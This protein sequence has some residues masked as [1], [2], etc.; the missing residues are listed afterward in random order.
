MSPGANTAPSLQPP[1]QKVFEIR[2]LDCISEGWNFDKGGGV[3]RLALRTPAYGYKWNTH[4][5]GSRGQVVPG[6][7]FPNSLGDGL[8]RS[9]VQFGECNAPC[10]RQQEGEACGSRRRPCVG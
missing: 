1:I 9:A 4:W 6:P 7:D 3:T 5:T 8:D 10:W 2:T